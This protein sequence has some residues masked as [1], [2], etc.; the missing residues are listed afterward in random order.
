[1]NDTVLIVLMF[2]GVTAGIWLSYRLFMRGNTDPEKVAASLPKGFKPDW[3]HRCGDT[4]AGYEAAT[5]RLALVDW[6]HK[7]LV[8][9]HE[10]Q[11]VAPEDERILGVGHRWIVVTVATDPKPFRIWFRF[12]SASRRQLLSRLEGMQPKSA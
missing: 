12:S 8:A 10:L 4:Y 7:A 1:V 5:N 6:P 11:S 9:P 3:S 2:G